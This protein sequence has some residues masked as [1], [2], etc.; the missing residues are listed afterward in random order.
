AGG[1]FL[2]CLLCHGELARQKPHPRYLTNFYLMISIG[3]AAGG[4][5]V[6]LLA[7]AV[8]KAYYELQIGLAASAAG[9]LLAIYHKPGQSWYRPVPI[10][11]LGLT[12]FL[13]G[14]LANE[15]RKMGEDTRL[16]VRNFYG[17]LRVTEDEKGEDAV[18][19]LLHGTI[20]HGEQFLSTAR[21]I[22]PTTYYS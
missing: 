5:F 15:C 16:M 11:A 14:Y 18:R 13:F 8:F 10:I 6:A 3:G 21:R 1:L 12:A 9:A 22:L 4:L 2:C 7:P 19:K 17:G 20:N